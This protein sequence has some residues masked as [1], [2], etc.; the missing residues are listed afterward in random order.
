MKM[1]IWNHAPSNA[2][3]VN[4][5]LINKLISDEN[6]APFIFEIKE[7]FN[8]KNVINEINKMTQNVQKH[9]DITEYNIES[10]YQYFYDRVLMKNNN[11]DTRD[12]VALFIGIL[13]D[14]KNYYLHPKKK[15]TLVAQPLNKEFSVK[16]DVIRLSS[17]ILKMNIQ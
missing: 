6:I 2:K 12:V 16:S 15:N 3:F 9:I 14:S 13:T 17:I 7:G 10:V 4:S 11:Y 1:L 8:W 5:E